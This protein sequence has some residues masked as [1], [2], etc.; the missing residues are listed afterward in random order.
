GNVIMSTYPMA[1][2]GASTIPGDTGCYTWLSGTSMASPH[3]AGAAAL[4]WSRGD[5]T[6][7]RQVVD[8]LLGSADPKGVASTRLDSWTV[9]GGLNIHDALS[10]ATTNLPPVADAGADQSVDDIN[11]DGVE[12]VTLDGSASLDQDGRIA[13]YSWREASTVLGSGSPLPVWLSVGSHTLTLEVTDDGGA[14]AVDDVVVA[15]NHIN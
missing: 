11:G 1:A 5:V 7:N 15:V 12:L 14:T 3:V 8:I 9:H 2:C 13:S 10:Y 6:S 4:V